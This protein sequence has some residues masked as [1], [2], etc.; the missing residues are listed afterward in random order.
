MARLRKGGVLMGRERRSKFANDAKT[1]ADISSQ[2]AQNTTLISKANENVRSKNYKIE[3]QMTFVS[4]DGRLEDYTVVKDIISRQQIS[5]TTAVVTN[6]VPTSSNGVQC[7]LAQLKELQDVY[8]WEIV[9][10][11]HSH[12]N[13]SELATEQEVHDQF[14]QSRDWLKENGFKG[15][16]VL[17]YP[18]NLF[19]LR[20]K[21]IAP[22]YYDCARSSNYGGTNFNSTPVATFE[23]KSFFI[24]N[25]PAVNSES[26]FPGNSLNHYKFLIDRAVTRNEWLILSTHSWEISQ[27]GYQQLL[28]DII[29]YA[30]TKL[31]IVSMAQGL[32]NI[33]NV[34]DAGDYNNGFNDKFKSHFSVGAGGKV[35]SNR[36]NSVQLLSDSVD[37]STHIDS[38]EDNMLTIC[39]VSTNKTGFP[40]DGTAQP[41][42]GILYTHKFS[43]SKNEYDYY[44]QIFKVY[45]NENEY[46]RKCNNDGTW[47]TW[48]QMLTK[49]SNIIQRLDHDT[50]D[51]ATLLSTFPDK[52]I[53]HVGVSTSKAISSGLPEN[54]AGTL[55]TDRTT[56]GNAYHYQMYHLYASN[57]VYKRGFDGSAWLSWQ[58]VNTD[59]LIIQQADDA[60]NNSSAPSAFTSNR[61]SY[62]RI[63]TSNASGFPGN[64]A[65][66]LVTNKMVPQ[67]GFMYQE[68]HQYNT[69]NLFKRFVDAAGAWSAWKQI[70]MA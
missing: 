24:T 62:C 39:S 10:H 57:N 45:G 26:G 2:L 66:V 8:G 4:D 22:I 23:L 37:G 31:K 41:R 46:I 50:Q 47:G 54:K 36:I 60:V 58:K 51:G 55:V 7:T 5:F 48:K 15:Y 59:S 40:L 33:K 63:G 67:N 21:K 65:G 12:A 49:E 19:G 42:A 18:Y 25:L 35:S 6:A 34:I 16:N 38:Y 17:C 11:T 64:L 28:E 68:Y 69:G 3:P 1:T 56:S 27:W 44:Y 70:T 61:I 29:S 43:R 20:E 9:S 32:E 13:L 52:M 53:T 30:K 14:R